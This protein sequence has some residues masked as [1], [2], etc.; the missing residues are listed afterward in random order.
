MSASLDGQNL[1]D[2]CEMKIELGST[3]RNLIERTIAGLD[4]VLSIDLGACPRKLKQTGSLRAKSRLQMNERINAILGYMDGKA[5]TLVTSNEGEFNNL[6]MDDFKI[7]KKLAAGDGLCCD[8][9][10]IYTQLTV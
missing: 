5:H 4:G 8:Y 9:E 10:V 3:R 2:E 1:F 6:R 7:T